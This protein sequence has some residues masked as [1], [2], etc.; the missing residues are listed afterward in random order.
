MLTEQAASLTPPYQRLLGDAMRG[1]SE[2]FGRQDIVE[3]QWRIVE[4]ILDDPP[5]VSANTS[6]EAGAR[7]RPTRSSAP[8][9]RGAIPSRRRRR[10]R[11][12]TTRLPVRRR[13]H[14]ARQRRASRTICAAHLSDDFG[15]AAEQR[16]WAIFEELRSE[17]GY[18]DYLG[19]LE[20]YRV[21]DLHDPRLLADVELA[22]R[23]SVRRP[24]L[25]AARSTPCGM[26]AMGPAGRAFGRRRRLPA[27][28][29]RAIRALEGVRRRHA[30][31]H[32]QGAGAGRRRAP[33]SGASTTC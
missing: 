18:A 28:Q 20:R 12:W 17:L 9:G 29:G 27:A 31:L 8:T 5:A 14:A 15:E 16:Y 25:S 11:P 2:L 21:E 26:S 7:R 19:A 24:A 32:P 10:E 6:R 13:Q 30:D 3:A 23:L 33:L 4:P 22:G 1:D